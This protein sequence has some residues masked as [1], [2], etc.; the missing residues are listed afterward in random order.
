MFMARGAIVGVAAG[1]V[2]C[3]L[4]LFAM[5]LALSKGVLVAGLTFA[6]AMVL[7]VGLT[8]VVVATF[9]VLARE[10]M[11]SIFGRHGASV[12]HISRTL[13]FATGG[14]LLVIGA[15]AFV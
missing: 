8:L 4:T 9:T 5:F 15:L 14:L 1:L 3:P 13:D 11:L 12:E 10:R 6:A 7:G 2:P